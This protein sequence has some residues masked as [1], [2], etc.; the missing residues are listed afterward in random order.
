MKIEFGEFRTTDKHRQAVADVLDSNWLTM[1]PKVKEFED[2]F[3]ALFDYNYCTMMSSGTAADTACCLLLREL[4]AQ[5]G[6]EVIIPALTFIATAEAVKFAGLKPVLVD[7]GWDLQIDINQIEKAITPKTKAIMAVSLMGKPCNLAAIRDLCNKYNLLFI[8]DNC[9]AYGSKFEGKY[10]LHYA[11]LETTSHFNAHISFA[12]EGGC[13]FTNNIEYD[14]IL[15]AIRSHGRTKG[16]YFHHEY[17]G[18]NF[19]PTDLHAAIGCV[20]LDDFWKIWNA[21]KRNLARMNRG[22]YLFKYFHEFIMNF[23]HFGQDA[24]HGFSLVLRNPDHTPLFIE[25]MEKAGI[26]VKRNFGV[27]N[28]HPAFKDIEGEFP[29]ARYIGNN[30]VHWGV[31]QYMSDSDIDYIINRVEQFYEKHY[32]SSM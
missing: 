22:F 32:Q 19:K 30:G 12:V 7:V 8:L 16:A 2:K 1:G 5:E 25:H 14:K 13:V 27:I 6:D 21:R 3:K 4:G 20:E 26:H 31:H 28:E 29:V 18:G 11:D 17:L 23:D 24:P 9:E 15:R 10:S